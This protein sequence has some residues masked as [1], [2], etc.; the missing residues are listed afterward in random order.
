VGLVEH[1]NG[2]SRMVPADSWWQST[3]QGASNAQ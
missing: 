3:D 1:S 2:Q